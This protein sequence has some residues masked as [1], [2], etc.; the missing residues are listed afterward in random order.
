MALIWAV[1]CTKDEVAAPDYS[2][3]LPPGQMALVKIDAPEDIPDF[4]PSWDNRKDLVTAIDWSLDYFAHPSSE[5]YF[6]Y[7]DVTHARAVATLRA[8]KALLDEVASGDELQQRVVRDFEVYRS[9]GYDGNG[10]LLYTGYC[11]P[12]YEGSPVRTADFRYPLYKLPTDLEKDGEGNCL[13]RRTPGGLV[14]YW[15]RAD[16]EQRRLLDGLELVWLKSRLEVYIIHVQGS[17]LLRMPDGKIFEVGY[18]GNNG[19]DYTSIGQELVETGKI[20]RSELSL[21]AIKAYFAEHPEELEEYMYRNKRYIF[22]RSA[23]GGPFGS[24]GAPVTALR[25]IATDK[26]VYPRGCLAFAIT[27]VP[28]IAPDGDV[29]MRHF[30]N[31]VCDQDTGG[32]IRAAGRADLFMGTG[33]DAELLA[34][35]IKSE[36][37]LYYIFLKPPATSEPAED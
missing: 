21:S 17:A 35:R 27:A 23:P 28:T 30:A 12:V 26:Q 25:S 36:G 37:R 10:V 22:F 32:A 15:T 19:F 8:F 24:L 20:A 29:D 13:G 14:P 3:P 9:V 7:L 18:D 2:R 1:G 5:G 31:W 33:P 16:I 4:R 6:P 34:G 11:Q